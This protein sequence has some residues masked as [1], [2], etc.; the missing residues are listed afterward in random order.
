MLSIDVE[1][2]NTNMTNI[3]FLVNLLQV[4]HV[5]FNSTGLL[6]II[7]I[8]EYFE[9]SLWWTL[10]KNTRR[11]PLFSTSTLH[12]DQKTIIFAWENRAADT[13]SHAIARWKYTKTGKLVAIQFIFRYLRTTFTQQYKQVQ[14]GTS[15]YKIFQLS[16]SLTLSYTLSF[17]R[18]WEAIIPLQ[19]IA[20][21][22][23]EEA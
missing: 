19:R 13:N 8:L 3:I 20:V 7:I 23:E 18:A 1:E 12:S 2:R 6:M 17:R 10:N 5:S 16:S 22:R 15:R 21:K 14:A 4:G 9:S 11:L